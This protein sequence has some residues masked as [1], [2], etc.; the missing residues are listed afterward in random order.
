MTCVSLSLTRESR[1][2]RTLY[3]NGQRPGSSST[4]IIEYNGF[5]SLVEPDALGVQQQ[6]VFDNLAQYGLVVL[7]WESVAVT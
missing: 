1:Y 2:L 4:P 5:G 6:R 3:K 7:S